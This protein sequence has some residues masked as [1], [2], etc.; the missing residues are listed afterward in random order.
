MLFNSLG[1]LTGTLSAE[2]LQGSNGYK[3]D[4]STLPEGVY[5]AQVHLNGT[6]ST[7]RK[8]VVSR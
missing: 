5:F 1:M 2:G 4:V 6:L 8:F 7:T 3:F